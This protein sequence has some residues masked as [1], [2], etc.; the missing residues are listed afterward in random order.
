MKA[1]KPSLKPSAK[2]MQSG[3][4]GWILLWLVGIPVPILLVL[5]LLRGCT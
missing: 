2:Q 5:F 1:N 4:V 3:K